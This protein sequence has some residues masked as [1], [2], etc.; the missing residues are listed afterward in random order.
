VTRQRLREALHELAPG[1]PLW[2]F[3]SLVRPGVFNAPSDIDIAFTTLP[4]GISEFS[5]GAELEE[6]LGRPVDA[7][8]LTRTRLRKKI[9]REGERWI[10]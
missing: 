4:P 2:D 3:G 7:I 8:D 6:R 1:L 10:A 9:E 5:L